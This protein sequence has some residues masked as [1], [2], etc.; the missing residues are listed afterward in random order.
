MLPL[1]NLQPSNPASFDTGLNSAELLPQEAAEPSAVFADLLR[2]GTAPAGPQ[3]PLVGISLP[4]PGNDL[5]LADLPVA[6]PVGRDLPDAET[7]LPLQVLHAPPPIIPVL[8]A[9]DDG[10]LRAAEG[11]A[12]A[13][14]NG[15]APIALA[16]MQPE[17]SSRPALAP[18]QLSVEQFAEGTAVRQD[19]KVS[20]APALAPLSQRGTIPVSPIAEPAAA[21]TPAPTVAAPADVAEDILP[22]LLRPAASAAA[23]TVAAGDASNTPVAERLPTIAPV[24]RPELLNDGRAVTPNTTPSQ[25]AVTT[26]GPAGPIEVSAPAAQATPVQPSQVQAPSLAVTTAPA[27]TPQPG[28]AID[29]PVRDAAW[30]EA[31]GERVLLMASNRLQNAELRLTPAELGPLRVQVAVDDGLA[32]V[33]FHA[34]HALTREALEQALPRL[35][36]LLAENGLTLNQATVGQE[37]D[38]GLMHGN[39]DRD[40]QAAGSAA[41]V[42]EPGTEPTLP[43]GS[44]TP[45]SKPRPDGLVDTFA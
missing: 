34:Q 24:T 36:D 13:P 6:A 23:A 30:G 39:R 45:R 31:I 19:S 18:G 40:G 8:P 27:A 22:N 37:S 20:A 12:A 11:S 14:K 44:E 5:P 42:S 10:R 41:D 28:Q 43:E 32:N 17:L 25:P 3:Q 15:P 21:S 2:L 16:T 35:R 7:P 9:T 38:Q 1:I 33:T 29:V 26:P 4:Q